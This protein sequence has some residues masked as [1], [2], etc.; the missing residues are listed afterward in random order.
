MHVKQK[1]VVKM[2]VPAL[3][4]R[5]HSSVKAA[6]HP[7]WSSKDAK[8][9][10]LYHSFNHSNGREGAKEPQATKMLFGSSKNGCFYSASAEGAAGLR[11]LPRE[12]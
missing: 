1:R 6:S 7:R 3:R 9:L 11:S 12:S 8:M 4:V 2:E 5:K 10:T